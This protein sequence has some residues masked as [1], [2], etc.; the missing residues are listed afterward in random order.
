M[1]YLA[2]YPQKEDSVIKWDFFQ[3]AKA[4]IFPEISSEMEELK[5]VV[6]V[7]DIDEMVI[8]S[9]M[10]IYADSIKQKVVCYLK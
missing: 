10:F 8:N 7:I 9:Q 2:I 3:N 1:L 5:D 6:K 4:K